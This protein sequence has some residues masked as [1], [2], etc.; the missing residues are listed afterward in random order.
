M[1]DFG[2]IELI[3]FFLCYNL[4]LFKIENAKFHIDKKDYTV[5]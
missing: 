3:I 1:I 2:E 5:N 4:E